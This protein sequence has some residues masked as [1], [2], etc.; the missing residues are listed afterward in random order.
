MPGRL[1]SAI[2]MDSSSSPF[3]DLQPFPDLQSNRERFLEIAEKRPTPFFLIEGSILTD[4][5]DAMRERLRSRW[6]PSAIA[7]S[8]KTNYQVAELGL[9]RELGIRAEVVSGREYAMARRFGYAGPE[10]VFNGPYKTDAE[11]ERALLDGCVL[12][13]HGKAE[14]ERL[15]RVATA[16]G[17]T[18]DV[19]IRVAALLPY[20]GHSRFGFSLDTDEAAAAVR[21][22]RE[23]PALELTGLHF[24][25]L[26]D[27]TEPHC[28]QL[29][30]R[31]L[32]EFAQKSIP[33]YSTRLRTLDLGGGFPSH[34]LKPRNRESY[35]PPPIEEFIDA[36][37]AELEPAFP[38]EARP[39]LILE[40][41][42]YLVNDAVMLVA[43]VIDVP[44]VAPYDRRTVLSNAS[45][46]MVPLTHYC[47][48]IIRPYTPALEP[49]GGEPVETILYGA[50][51][52]EDDVL[53]EG[54]LAPVQVGDLLVYYAVG[55]YNANLGPDFIF[56][57]PPLVSL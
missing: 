5:A 38:G 12:H 6:G 34:G 49:R 15:I 36:I 50:S 19:G 42:R 55:A 35:D 56:E 9:L 28:N 25:G 13:V 54:P 39:T 24:H 3:R 47:P 8:F 33:D 7:Y 21:R 32:A 53:H 27:T 57:V 31:K 52:R 14:L 11:L 1:H 30:A 29:A 18:Y 41:G 20:F 22:I 16:L 44:E 10:I 45:I 37:V 26:G 43:E 51:C 17:G 48:Q 4:R 46:T 2:A 23:C 40:P